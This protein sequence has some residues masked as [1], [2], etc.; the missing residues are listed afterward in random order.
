MSALVAMRFNPDLKAKCRQLLKAGKAPK[1]VITAIMR[2]K[3]VLA[4]AILKKRL[5]WQ[6]T[7]A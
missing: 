1:I 4:N 6:P 7:L 2:K 5:A 3:I